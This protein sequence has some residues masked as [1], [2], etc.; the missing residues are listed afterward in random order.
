MFGGFSVAKCD[1]QVQ[2]CLGRI[3]IQCNKKLLQIRANKREVAELL[4]LNKTDNAL[5]RVEGVIRET[6]MI[7]VCRNALLLAA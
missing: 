5:I 1:I 4:T 7:K 2:L 3:K 6:E